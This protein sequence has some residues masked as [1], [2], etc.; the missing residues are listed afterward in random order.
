MVREMRAFSVDFEFCFGSREGDTIAVIHASVCFPVNSRPSPD[1]ASTLALPIC[2]LTLKS[3]RALP[4]GYPR[5]LNTLGDH[6]RKKRL[7]L[8]L[9][10]KDAA[11]EIGVDD[12]TLRH[13]ENHQTSPQTYLIPRIVS[14]LSYLPY[15]PPESFAEWLKT[16]RM[17]LGLSRRRLAEALGVDTSTV[18][19]WETGRHKPT[20]RN[21]ERIE[22]FLT[23]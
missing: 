1:R 15:V 14:F 6:I 2:H 11:R 19:G 12:V 16:C 10:Q 7:D 3:Q 20:D 13:W 18:S 17:A 22:A 5:D 4:K 9:T 23:S 21:R 8:G